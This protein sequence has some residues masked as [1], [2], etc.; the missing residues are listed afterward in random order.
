VLNRAREV[1]QAIRFKKMRVNPTRME[2]TED[3][4]PKKEVLDF[5]WSYYKRKK[6]LNELSGIHIKVGA[7]YVEFTHHL[8]IGALDQEDYLE[9]LQLYYERHEELYQAHRR[10]R[11]SRLREYIKSAYTPV[12]NAFRIRNPE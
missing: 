9:H 1:K 6:K 4:K 8:A 7:T 3:W 10:S 11:F 2:K 12:L 5:S